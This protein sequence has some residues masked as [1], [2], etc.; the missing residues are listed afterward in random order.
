MEISAS[1][2]HRERGASFALD[3]NPERGGCHTGRPRQFL[4]R[5]QIPAG[6]EALRHVHQRAVIPYHGVAGGSKNALDVNAVATGAAHLDI[7]H[8]LSEL[9]DWWQRCGLEENS[10]VVPVNCGAADKNLLRS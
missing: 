8:E 9:P 3:K 1:Q 10:D 7:D 2:A 4:Q 5:Q 6:V